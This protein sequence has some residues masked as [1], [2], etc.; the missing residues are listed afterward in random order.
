MNSTWWPLFFF[1][2]P[3]LIWLPSLQDHWNMSLRCFK[4]NV[5]IFDFQTLWRRFP[6]IKIH[7]VASQYSLKMS[8]FS[9]AVLLLWVCCIFKIFL[10]VHLTRKLLAKCHTTKKRNCVFVCCTFSLTE[11]FSPW[12]IWP[13]F[14]CG[15]GVEMQQRL[16]RSCGSCKLKDEPETRIW[17]I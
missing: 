16:E 15:C 5:V 17:F 3:S 10:V 12:S 2:A 1:H 4:K 8:W 11:E 9:V 7:D 6:N 13:F 14:R